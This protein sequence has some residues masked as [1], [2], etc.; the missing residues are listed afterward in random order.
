VPS[1]L[2]HTFATDRLTTNLI[3]AANWT[4]LHFHDNICSPALRPPETI[5]G[6]PFDTSADIWSFGC[7]VRFLVSGWGPF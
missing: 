4:D 7:T 1:L 5:L 3:V 6:Y 2:M